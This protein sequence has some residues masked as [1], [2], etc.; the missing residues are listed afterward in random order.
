MKKT[1]LSWSSGKDSAWSLYQLQKDTK[2][3]LVALATVFNQ[4]HDRVAMHAVRRRL[5]RAQ[6]KAAGLPL[7]EVEIPYG[8]S[9]A[10]YEAAM[11]GLIERCHEHKVDAMAFGDLF[12]EDIRQY[13]LKNL[14]GTG[15]EA[16]FPLWGKPTDELAKE[17]CDGGLKAWI[18]CVDPKQLDPIFAGKPWQETLAVKPPQGVDPCCEN[19]EA[20]TF[21]W[22]G[23]MFKEEIVCEVGE[24]G[25]VVERDGFYF[26]DLK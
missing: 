19:G 25:E 21:T 16:L 9:N 22:A 8:A 14:K 11:R 10:V 24:V 20:H 7:W 15:I 12:L 1:V 3:E 5:A 4:T 17:M 26:A 18:T 23:P 2:I 6:A 13:R